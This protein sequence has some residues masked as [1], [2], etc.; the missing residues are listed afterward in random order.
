MRQ[1]LLFVL[2]HKQKFLSD[3]ILLSFLI[4]GF[5]FH[6]IKNNIKKSLFFT[7]KVS[8]YTSDVEAEAPEA[9]VFWWKQ[10]RLK[11]FRFRSVSKLAYKFWQIFDNQKLFVLDCVYVY[12]NYV[13]IILVFS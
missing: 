6:F 3:M 4:A 10:K 2:N 7:L 13:Q 8:F 9:V 1:F 11:I 12:L 5:K